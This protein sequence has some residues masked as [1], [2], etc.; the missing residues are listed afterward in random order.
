M[1]PLDSGL[2][3][4]ELWAIRNTEIKTRDEVYDARCTYAMEG[5]L[6]TG[7]IYRR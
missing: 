1:K 6:K 3:Q 7:E 2:Q 4:N 5:R